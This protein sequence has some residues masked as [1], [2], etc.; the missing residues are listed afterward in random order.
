MQIRPHVTRGQCSQTGVLAMTSVR[1]P[2]KG[3]VS[4]V[5]VSD[6]EIWAQTDFG[7]SLKCCKKNFHCSS[8]LVHPHTF[9]LY[10]V[11]EMAIARK[12]E[13]GGGGWEGWGGGVGG[14]GST[15][16]VAK[17]KCTTC[18]VAEDANVT[19]FLPPILNCPDRFCTDHPYCNRGVA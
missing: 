1:G 5:T 7:Q 3:P 13:V 8:F 16:T 19:P 6:D 18:R 15:S 17:S 11:S 4:R 9:L 10:N 14:L 12:G 2:G